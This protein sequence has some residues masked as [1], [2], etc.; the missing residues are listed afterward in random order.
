M[1]GNEP[2]GIPKQAGGRRSSNCDGKND[3]H[4]GERYIGG[5]SGLH[6]GAQWYPSTQSR[7]D[8]G[9][10]GKERLMA[11][12]V[13][14]PA[15]L[16]QFATD[17]RRF[18]QEPD[19]HMRVLQT[20]IQNLS[21]TWRDQEQVKFSAEFEEALRSLTRFREASEVHAP[22]LIRKAERVEE[23]LKQR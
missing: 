18:N 17:L 5:S 8:S 11:K 15:E 2:K 3:P 16:R 7:S 22:F 9:A 21:Q 6:F 1:L 13:V 4:W 19:N 12:A 23:Y 14:D 10:T 20:R